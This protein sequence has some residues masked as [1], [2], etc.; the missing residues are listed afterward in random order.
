MDAAQAF[1]IHDVAGNVVATVLVGLAVAAWR[2]I[3]RRRARNAPQPEPDSP[4]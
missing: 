3:K 2:W 1:L 4:E